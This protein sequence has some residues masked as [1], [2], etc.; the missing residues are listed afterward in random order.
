MKTVLTVAGSDPSGGAGVQADLKTIAAHGLYGMSVVTALTVQ[1][2][3]GVFG[4]HETPAALVRAQLDAVCGDIPPDAVKVGMLGTR[5]TVEAVADGLTAWGVRKL[6]V[7]PVMVSTSGRRLLA[8]DAAAALCARLLPRA[9][10]ITPNLPETEALWGEPVR[11]KPDMEAAARALEERFDCAVLVK[12]GHRA[13]GADDV[14]CERGAVTWFAGERIDN[15]N[16]HGTGCTLSSAIACG[17]AQGATLAQSVAAAKAFLTGALRA[18]LTLGKGNG[19][20]DHLWR[21]REK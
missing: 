19:P 12:G 13:G 18:G 11:E 1:N 3:Q 6:V 9:A 10:L 5:E 17:L 4:V 16:T 2:T 7:D 15:A 14:L 8:E 21:M 20:L